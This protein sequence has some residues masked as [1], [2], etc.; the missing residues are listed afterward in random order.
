[1]EIDKDAPKASRYEW[2]P[3]NVIDE[4]MEAGFHGLHDEAKMRFDPWGDRHRHL[5][6]RGVR[7]SLLVV[8]L[9]AERC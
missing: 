9:R 7:S 6:R 5:C 8:R 1:M 4:K 3:T 2:V